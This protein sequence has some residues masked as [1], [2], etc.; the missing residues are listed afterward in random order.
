LTNGNVHTVELVGLIVGAV[1]PLLV[2]HGVQSDGSLTGLTITDNQL[3]L[4]TTDGD[5]GVDRLETGLDGLVDGLTGENARGLD[6][7]TTLLL[8]VEGTLSV[9]GVTEGIDD[10][11]EKLGSDRDI[12]NLS[13]TLDGL[14][15]LD[16][17]VRTEKHNTDLAGFQVHAHA[18]DTGGELDKLLS[19]DVV[20]AV[21]TGNTV[22]DGE[23]TTSLG[24]GVLLLDTADPL[25]QDGRN[26]GRG[27][28]GL[29][30]VATEGVGERRSAGRSNPAG[31]RD[32]SDPAARLANGS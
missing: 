15:L 28:L 24:E 14:T 5:H 19:L 7:S 17:T 31:G 3:T 26:F 1:P 20:H 13:G 12:D 8:G 27:G 4:T 11:A 29:G 22:T 23:N 10:T 2:K 30:S 9:D 6:L 16:E 18:L 21:D 25:L 32:C